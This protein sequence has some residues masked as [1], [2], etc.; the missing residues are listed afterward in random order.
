[1][2]LPLKVDKKFFENRGTLDPENSYLLKKDGPGET[3][4]SKR[5]GCLPENNPFD[6]LKC[7]PFKEKSNMHCD[8]EDVKNVLDIDVLLA[9]SALEAVTATFSLVHWEM[10]RISS[11]SAKLVTLKLMSILGTSIMAL[12]G[13]ERSIASMDA[14]TMLDR[15]F[16]SS[17]SLKIKS[18]LIT[19][20]RRSGQLSQQVLERSSI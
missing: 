7:F 19:T 9:N 6:D 8:S 4:E 13:V 14:I 5:K 11:F 20:T 18:S 12:N 16:F 1:M 10:A 2:H 15:L 3:P 17:T